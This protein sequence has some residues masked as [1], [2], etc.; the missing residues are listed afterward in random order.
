V[1]NEIHMIKSQRVRWLVRV[2]L[3]KCVRNVV[4]NDSSACAE[5]V[6]IWNSEHTAVD[7]R[8][9]GNKL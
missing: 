9:L 1:I 5:H 4:G 8:N 6:G 2:T 7:I 3:F